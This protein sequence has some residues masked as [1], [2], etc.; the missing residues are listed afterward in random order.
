MQQSGRLINFPAS[1]QQDSDAAWRVRAK[2]ISICALTVQHSEK[3]CHAEKEAT[4]FSAL[5]WPW[6][7][8]VKMLIIIWIIIP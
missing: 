6:S 7:N 1:N 3:E 5:C 8:K 2:A 4:S